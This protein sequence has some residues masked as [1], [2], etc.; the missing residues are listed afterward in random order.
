MKIENLRLRNFQSYDSADLDFDNGV[1]LIHGDNG[2]GKSTILRA[3]F[4][5]LFQADATSETSADYSLADLVRNTEDEGSVE[6][7][8]SVGDDV[9]TIEWVIT[10]TLE[11]EER[12]GSTKSCVLTGG[13]LEEPIS[14]V[15]EVR[16]MVERIIGMD[17]TSFA[18]SV[19][20]QQKRLSRLIEANASERKEILDGLLGLTK[21]D[22][23]TRRMKFA[24][25]PVRSARDDAQS[26]RKEVQ[27]RIDSY[28]EDALT[29]EQQ[30][31][32]DEI[33]TLEAK[34]DQIKDIVDGDRK[35]LDAVKSDLDEY[36]E[37]VEERNKLQNR[38]SGRKERV[39][40]LT[41]KIQQNESTIDAKQD[42]IAE[43][44]DQLTD[45]SEDVG[46]YDLTDTDEAE[47]AATELEKE[48][49]EAFE[50]TQSAK[51]T[52]ERLEEEQ[53]R[54][55]NEVAAAEESLTEAETTVTAVQDELDAATDE[56]DAV[57]DRVE[58]LEEKLDE[59]LT[60]LQTQ[61]N[62]VE[63]D[64][65]DDITSIDFDDPDTV[66]K[67]S[68]TELRD[69][70]DS[71][72]E[73][74]GNDL[75]ELSTKRDGIVEQSEQ[76][77]SELADARE[78]QERL[79]ERV[80]S[81]VQNPE[82]ELTECFS[83]IEAALTALGVEDETVSA[84]TLD[85]L[86]ATT[87]PRERSQAIA[88]LRDAA[89][90]I[91][92]TRAESR[93]HEYVAETLSE[94]GIDPEVVSMSTADREAADVDEATAEE[95]FEAVK[96]RFDDLDRATTSVVEAIQ[97]RT[98]SEV[99]S[100]I[101][102]LE[103]RKQ[104]L[105][106]D[107][108]DLRNKVSE[109]R[110]QKETLEALVTEAKKVVTALGL[111]AEAE[112]DLTEAERARTEHETALTEAEEAVEQAEGEVQTT[113]AALEETTSNLATA[114][115]DLTSAQ[116]TLN[117]I[118]Y[119]RDSAREAAECHGAI[120]DCVTA[121]EA[122]AESIDEHRETLDAVQSDISEYRTELSELESTLDANDISTLQAKKKDYAE[123]VTESEQKLETAEEKHSTAQTH[124]ARVDE[125]LSALES[126]RERAQELDA[127]VKWT[128][129]IEQ[130][131]TTIIDTYQRVKMDLREQTLGLLN[132]YTNEVF[133]D[134]YQNESYVGV[135]IDEDYGI[136]LISGDG[137]AI[138]PNKCSGGEG[139]LTNIALRA[140]V[141]RVI[142]EQDAAAGDGLPPFLLDEPTNFLDDTHVGQIEGVIHSIEEW[143]VPQVIL[144]SHREALMFSADQKFYVSKDPTSDTS[145]VAIEDD[146]VDVGSDPEAKPTP[147]NDGGNEQ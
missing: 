146:E 128:D 8:F 23:Y 117:T 33:A 17:A 3:I 114:R 48:W 124:L 52:V 109:A 96:A 126:E 141:Y 67:E 132:K 24:R 56:Y 89:E 130:E 131:L 57:E 54:L 68:I 100:T 113:E 105:E 139:V 47:S 26:R 119:Q 70:L 63:F 25:R 86:L 78:K 97:L 136:E 55:S 45:L 12:K 20:V 142:A 104:T 18:N 5:G 2:A 38:I 91:A 4:S 102:E 98:L 135:R 81:D 85:T 140:G 50:T 22:D 79:L 36:H 15:R 129:D 95:A 42:E 74:L 75:R 87:L 93:Y 43:L 134:L 123:N 147:V 49:Q 73:Q 7:T 32:V 27:E 61:L 118:E 51:S 11:D 92:Q 111:L 16:E 110:S 120:N 13:R 144:V 6:L 39:D 84:D 37:T 28:D 59:A 82:T 19:Y 90:E 127:R 108:E 10:V 99:F 116:E 34:R 106:S 21:L 64:L 44:E 65:S 69:T 76:L 71:T 46:E 88:D 1:T 41:T 112:R 125:K 101:S 83:G 31:L 72:R 115:D 9:Y 122:A 121:I 77:D 58:T 143:D 138:D 30:E 35:R 107:A 145:S 29:T 133:G 40:E 66:T 60:T 94:H 53:Q 103:A 80:T 137:T 14:G 62:A